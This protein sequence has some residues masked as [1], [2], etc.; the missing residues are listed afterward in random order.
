MNPIFDQQITLNQALDLK[1]KIE[2]R[3]I[4]DIQAYF[5]YYDTYN[6]I[7]KTTV[8][9]IDKSSNAILLTRSDYAQY[10]QGNKPLPDGYG[11]ASKDLSSGIYDEL[12]DIQRCDSSGNQY[13]AYG[14]TMSP[15]MIND[16]D[17]H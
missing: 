15:A 4:P 6:S 16:Y 1:T 2:A 7:G 17:G 8:Y 12:L 5:K 11:Y 10:I 14:I 13:R 3:E 9:Y